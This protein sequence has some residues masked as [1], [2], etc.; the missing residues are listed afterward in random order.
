ME[1]L[2][3]PSWWGPWP[4]SVLGRRPPLRRAGDGGAGTRAWWCREGERPRL[5][6]LL[7]PV[8]AS[9][10]AQ[11]QYKTS[12]CW[13][14]PAPSPTSWS[15]AAVL[16]LFGRVPHLAGWSL[17]EVAM[18]WG[19]SAI[20]FAVADMVATG[21]DVLPD[22]IRLGTFDRVLIRPLGAFFQTLAVTVTLRRVGRIAQ[23]VVILGLVCNLLALT[24]TR[25]GWRCWPWPWSA[26]PSS[27]PSS[28]AGR[29]LVLD[30]R[31]PGGDEHLHL[32]RDDDGQLPPG[33]LRRVATPG[34]DLHP[35]PGLRQLLPRAVHPGTP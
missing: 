28:S 26:G 11:M 8:G 25:T 12:S 21:F 7:A 32:R 15:S 16:V 31:R 35:A 30:H 2:E 4:C 14:W 17:G 19:M 24:W 5:V 18:L 3:P 13:L 1:R 20:S 33:H 29:L 6:A 22:Q 10:R 27:S 9:T 23:G 34:G